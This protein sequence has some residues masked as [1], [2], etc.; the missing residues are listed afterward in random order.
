MGAVLIADPSPVWPVRGQ[1]RRQLTP[2]RTV[3]L[4]PDAVDSDE[5]TLA[6]AQ[7]PDQP[8]AAALGAG[9]GRRHRRIHDWNHW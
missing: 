3:Q 8:A 9:G 5:E 6:F 7:H 4:V 2:A 1:T